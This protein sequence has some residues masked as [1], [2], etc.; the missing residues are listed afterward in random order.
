M[1]N[2]LEGFVERQFRIEQYIKYLK[3][4]GKTLE[5]DTSF[6]RVELGLIDLT[7]EEKI[8]INQSL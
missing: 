8:L 1:F 5:T 3:E 2:M 7:S 4:N 6:E